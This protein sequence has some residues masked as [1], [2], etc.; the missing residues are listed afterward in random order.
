MPLR[1]LPV[2]CPSASLLT[3]R[4]ASFSTRPRSCYHPVLWSALLDGIYRRWYRWA[5]TTALPVT[6]RPDRALRSMPKEVDDEVV[7][8][9]P[10]A[11]RGRG[12][13]HLT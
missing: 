1:S 12:Q 5:L 6:P 10:A 4:L 8:G 2:P 13:G 11:Q 7:E 9:S 3:R